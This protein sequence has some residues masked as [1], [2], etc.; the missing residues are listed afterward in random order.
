VI[1]YG[2][3]SP[4]AGKEWIEVQAGSHRV[5]INDFRVA[6]ADG[7]PLWKGRQDKGH[8]AA[9]AVFRAAVTGSAELPA[10]LVPLLTEPAPLPT[11]ATLATMRAT[12][13]AADRAG[14]GA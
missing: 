6:E 12:I 4:V 10:G 7:K 8:R 2:S 9:V 5:V 3:A 14:A 13:E 11:A 1:G